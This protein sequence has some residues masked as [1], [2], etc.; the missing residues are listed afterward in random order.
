MKK[1]QSGFAAVEL[2]ILV[3]IAAAIA[4]V[5][6]FVIKNHNANGTSTSSFISAESS[7]NQG[8]STAPM[9]QVSST[10][11]LSTALNT[12]N[13]T[14]VGANSTDSSQLTTQSTGF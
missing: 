14:N 5:G 13:Q 1:Q 12:L 2:V 4:G 10:A 8:V 9:P 6:Y 11:D 3:V 7:T